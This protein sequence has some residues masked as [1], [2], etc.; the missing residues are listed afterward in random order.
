MRIAGRLR[1]VFFFLLVAGV[2]PAWPATPDPAAAL[3][4]H[5]AAL[6]GRLADNPFHRPLHLDSVESQNR[7][8]GDV[9][10]RVNHPLSVV[11]AELSRAEHWCDVLILHFNTKYCRAMSGRTGTVLAVRM[12]R[13]HEQPL[14]SAYH[15][16]FTFRV[17]AARADYL[18]IE[19][20]AAHADD[21]RIV[22]E[23]VPVE[24]GQTFLHLA[25]SY[26]RTL[27]SRT[28]MKSYLATLGR[29]KTGFT[30]TGRGTDGTPVYIDGVR[31]MIERNTM[32]YF[33]AVEAYLDA[34]SVP[35]AQR[36]EQRLQN[37]FDATARYPQQLYEMDRSTYLEMKR[38]EYRR[39]QTVRP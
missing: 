9:H 25:Y 38:R 35:P 6:A 12:G 3:H 1:T 30:V 20:H 28:A 39:Q 5:Y 4:A 7:L 27:A 31:G 8:S 21:D 22:L 37:W 14:V 23:A 10:A 18:R 16:D 19:L 33:L 15:I 24:N 32:R 17:T 36:P 29:E 13:K 11:G 34:L 2:T 26:T